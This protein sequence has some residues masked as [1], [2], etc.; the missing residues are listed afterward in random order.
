MNAEHMAKFYNSSGVTEGNEPFSERSSMLFDRIRTHCEKNV[1][2]ATALEIGCGN[3]R[4]SFELEKMGYA[5]TG[6]DCADKMIDYAKNFAKNIGSKA[7]FVVGNALE[8]PFEAD[9]FDSVFLLGNNIVEFSY[10][11]IDKMCC[12]IAVILKNS[13]VFCL[14]MND[15]FIHWNKGEPKTNFDDYNYGNSRLTNHY[16]IPK[17]GSTPY[18]SYIWTIGMFNFIAG[19]HFDLVDSQLIE[20]H[21]FWIE[22][23]I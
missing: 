3:G 1:A 17:F 2:S 4:W 10:D 21:R 9:L 6:I 12:Q 19:K 16:Q 23:R 14:E 13:G 15:M 20:G 5:I 8:M 11:D 18:H 7:K 22:C